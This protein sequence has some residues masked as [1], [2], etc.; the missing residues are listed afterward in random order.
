MFDLFDDCPA[1]EHDW[2]P[3]WVD[4]PTACMMMAD[5]M[6]EVPWKQDHMTIAGKNIALPRLT[7]W[8]GEPDAEYVYSGIRNVPV[9]WTPTVAELRDMLEDQLGLTFNSVLLNRYRG[10]DDSIGWHSDDEPE[11]GDEPVIASLS[12]GDTR[13]FEFR[14]K[15]TS[16]QLS[17][18]LSNGS[19]LVMKG[20]T[21]REWQHRVPKEPSVRGERINLT[22]RNIRASA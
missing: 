9:P 13:T 16:S 1:P 5:L 20:R 2:H 14:H 10:G 19:L 15:K 8:Q 21:Q 7:C 12:F 6:Q 3:R 18:P 11:L 22:F 4:Q 17:L